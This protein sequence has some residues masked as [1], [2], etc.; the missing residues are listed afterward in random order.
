MK[1]EWRRRL[2]QWESQEVWNLLNLIDT[3]RPSL[4]HQDEMRWKKGVMGQ[5]ST[6]SFSEIAETF[7]YQR[8][9]KESVTDF[10]GQKRAPLRAETVVWLMSLD[11]LKMGSYLLG[12]NFIESDQ[13][14]C[15]FCYDSIE[16]CS[17]I[18]FLCR[19]S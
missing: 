15:L 19:Y 5:Y 16:C 1:L 3:N 18:F 9:L 2:Y 12:L 7:I 8:I 6:K 11:R 17:Y 4:E 10:I 13:A 14:V